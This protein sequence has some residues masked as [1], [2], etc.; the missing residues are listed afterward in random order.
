MTLASILVLSL[1]LTGGLKSAPTVGAQAPAT[2][3]VEIVSVTGCLREQGVGNWVLVAA[4]DPVPS[5]ANQAPAA[6]L[7]KTPPA[8]KNT[9][10]LLGIGEFNLG[11]HR[12]RTMVIRG[13]LIK[14]SPVSRIN[15]TS[16]AEAVAS[17]VAGAPK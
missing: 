14:A 6:D 10:R 2:N 17:C 13:L 11:Q 16:S 8:G 3:K 9:F 15:M 1:A 7:P 12:D 4:T 5:A